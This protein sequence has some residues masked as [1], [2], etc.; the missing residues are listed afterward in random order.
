[1]GVAVFTGETMSEKKEKA[2]RVVP[3]FDAT[4]RLKGSIDHEVP[5]RAV[6]DRELTLMRKMHGPEAVVNVKQRDDSRAV[7][8]RH[9]LYQMA[10]KYGTSADATSGMKLIEKHLGVDLYGYEAW[11]DETLQIEEMEREERQA[12]DREEF[13]R[14]TQE[15]LT[16]AAARAAA[17]AQRAG[18]PA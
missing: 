10:R 7:S 1:V 8:E 15:Q 17:E 11:L 5:L 14:M 12:R 9:E 3:L 13:K 4:L 2:E 6:T 18:A 16:A